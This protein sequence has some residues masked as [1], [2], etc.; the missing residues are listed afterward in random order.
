M[1]ITT[2][3]LDSAPNDASTR[4][5]LTS[6]SS[7]VVKSRRIV[8]VTGAGIS[9]SCG[10]PD[11]RS[12]DGLYNLVKQ[13]YPDVV[14]KG[15]DLFDASLF[16][17]QTST[18]VFYTF[19]SGLKAA[20]DKA[21]PSPTH[22]FLNTLNKRG[23]LL[24]SYT[25][26]IDGLE[27]RSG[28]NGTGS[29][30][31]T[32]TT[33]E[34]DASKTEKPKISKD[35]KNIQLHGDIHKVRCTT[36]SA[37]FPFSEEHMEVFQKGTTTECPECK[38]RCDERV[39]RSARAL[40]VGSLRPAIV[41]Y[42]EAHPLGDDIAAIQTTD[43]GKRP[44]LLI[45]M[46]TSLKVH[47]CKKLVKDFAKA[48]RQNSPSSSTASPKVIFVNKT[49]PAAEWSTI[50]DVHVQGTTDA[51]VEKVLHDWKHSR[52]ADFEVQPTLKDVLVSKNVKASTSTP[53]AT[54]V[55]AKATK[56]ST[57]NS[58]NIAPAAPK[59]KKAATGNTASGSLS[60]TTTTTTTTNSDSSK[61]LNTKTSSTKA[62]LKD[63][64]FATGASVKPKVVKSSTANT[65]KASSSKST[66]KTENSE[67]NENSKK[68]KATAPL[69]K[70][71]STPTNRLSLSV[72]PPLSPSKR[73]NAE[74]HYESPD[75]LEMNPRKRQRSLNGSSDDLLLTLEPLAAC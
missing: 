34:T 27:E 50:I 36:C 47:G 6:L 21:E 23:K 10:I 61:P 63:R 22:H 57:P 33:T 26:N 64:V 14:I 1:P 66:T 9:C 8:V 18:A 48:I 69:E 65:A 68:G 20:I 39:A 52:P 35:T 56:R 73:Q 38:Q 43:L 28:L 37:M 17:D 67:N 51:W 53:S 2:L 24:R 4:R 72:T 44:D 30:S 41:L 54:K 12:S 16:R 74:S 46:G 62:I 19:I 32:S 60:I 25:Q 5:S 58:E 31:P 70:R 55:K 40:R 7:A 3:D 15:R 49:A 29:S 13:Q 71:S 59:A 42:D 75:G 45:I 11:F